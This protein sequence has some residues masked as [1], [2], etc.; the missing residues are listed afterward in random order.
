MECKAVREAL[1]AHLDGEDHSLELD[2]VE[3]HCASCTECRWWYN[4]VQVIHRQ[5]RVAPAPAVP[6]LTPAITLAVANVPLPTE[7]RQRTLQ[8]CRTLL[9]CCALLQ[10]VATLPMLFG[11]DTGPVHI[12]HE[13]GSWDAALSAGLLF[14][15]W[16]PARAW[17]MLPLVGAVAL[18]LGITAVTDVISGATSFGAESSHLLEGVGVLFLWTI[19]RITRDESNSSFRAVQLA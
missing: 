16:R 18:F 8:T 15:A 19:A 11:T 17:G 14:A 6:D 2:Y 7:A 10:L 13:L 3:S 5:V 12:D 1:S 4:Q 9:A